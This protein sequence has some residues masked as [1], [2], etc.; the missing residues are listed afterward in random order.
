MHCLQVFRVHPKGLGLPTFHKLLCAPYLHAVMAHAQP[1][2]EVLQCLCTCLTLVALA[3]RQLAAGLGKAAIPVE[4]AQLRKDAASAVLHAQ[5]HDG[6]DALDAPLGAQRY[7]GGAAE[8]LLPKPVCA[9]DVRPP[10]AEHAHPTR[11]RGR[12]RVLHRAEADHH[13]DLPAHGHDNV[14]I[15]GVWHLQVIRPL[16]GWWPRSYDS[17]VEL[18]AIFRRDLANA[19]RTLHCFPQTICGDRQHS[20]LVVGLGCAHMYPV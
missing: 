11:G 12:L 3:R 10:P 5:D 4:P 1:F 13:L 17:P 19:V 14:N 9:G 6:N 20:A 8:D 16:G 7:A 2:Q 15:I 18:L